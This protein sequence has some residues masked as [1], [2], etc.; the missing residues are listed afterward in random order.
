MQNVEKS[1]LVLNTYYAS[2]DGDNINSTMTW[3]NI[4]LRTLLG[5][6]YNK[7]KTYNLVLNKIVGETC[8]LYYGTSNKILD[9]YQINDTG[10]TGTTWAVGQEDRNLLIQCSGLPFYN[11]SIDGAFKYSNAVYENPSIDRTGVILGSLVLQRQKIVDSTYSNS[12]AT[13]TLPNTNLVDI[14]IS[15]VRHDYS[16]PVSVLA[17]IPNI[18]AYE[19]LLPQ[20]VF[21]FDIYG[22]EPYERKDFKNDGM[23]GLSI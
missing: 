6:L 23:I 20:L 7:Y 22:I 4:E 5:P 3:K 13:F 1:T 10:Q 2:D 14:K 11:N 8:S 18:D 21:I 12:I 9:V 16:T 19:N 17:A 15:L